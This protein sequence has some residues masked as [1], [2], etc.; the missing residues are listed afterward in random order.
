MPTTTITFALPQEDVAIWK[1]CLQKRYNQQED[2]SLALLSMLA[3]SEIVAYQI[4]MEQEKN[5]GRLMRVLTQLGLDVP[6]NISQM[7]TDVHK[8]V[9]R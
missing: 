3:V 7:V 5:E 6:R 8:A 4:R 2:T 9:A 1:Q